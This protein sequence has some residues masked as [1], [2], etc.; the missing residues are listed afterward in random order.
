MPNI[1]VS[2]NGPGP[3][4][5]S[6][7]AGALA[8]GGSLLGRS[9]ASLDLAWSV[10]ASQPLAGFSLST[11]AGNTTITAS[12]RINYRYAGF[13]AQTLESGIGI[14]LPLISESSF[15][16]SRLLSFRAG[17]DYLAE[18]DAASPFA[19]SDVVNAPASDWQKKISVRTG[20]ALAWQ[21]QGGQI[22]FNPPLAVEASLS[23]GTPLPLLDAG[24]PE[25]DF[26]LFFAL[27]VPSIFPHQALKLG[28]KATCVLG[29][30]FSAYS[31][32]FAVPRGFAG[33]YT[34][35]VPGGALASLDYLI[36]LALLDQPLLLGFAVTGVGLGVH[37]EGM[38]QWGATS[39]QTSVASKLF[40]GGDITF[41]LVYGLY[42]VPVGF[43]LAARIDTASP[44][45]FDVANDLRP[46]LFIGFDS[47]GSLV[48]QGQSF[49]VRAGSP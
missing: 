28:I 14:S 30:P 42:T 22:D 40:V 19:F 5:F 1:T 16:I 9:S 4:D 43:G 24:T 33:S 21:T 41:R 20:A 23:N 2:Q 47:F 44:G 39:G 10:G 46:Y 13:Y 31:D 18:R 37:A 26:A 35:A 29:G 15:G 25:S 6:F 27:T 36:P 8:I 34:R 17:L 32:E 11:M 3:L 7:G 38:G 49:R 12:S 48:K 45:S